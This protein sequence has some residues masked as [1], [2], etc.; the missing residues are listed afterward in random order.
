MKRKE[1]KGKGKNTV[2]KENQENSKYENQTIKE[3]TGNLD[4]QKYRCYPQT[5]EPAEI[6]QSTQ[7][8]EIV[9]F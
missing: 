1:T 9:L 7:R 2:I 8:K 4:I 3:R 5:K 6:I